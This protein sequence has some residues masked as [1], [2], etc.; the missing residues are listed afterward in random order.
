MPCKPTHD[1]DCIPRQVTSLVYE[2]SAPWI[3]PHSWHCVAPTGMKWRL[4]TLPPGHN[5]AA[6]VFATVA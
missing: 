5:R 1:V 2:I 3:Q 4:V 6:V